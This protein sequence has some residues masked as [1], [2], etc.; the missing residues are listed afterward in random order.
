MASLNDIIKHLSDHYEF[1]DSD[2]IKAVVIDGKL[3]LTVSSK[4]LQELG[5]DQLV[6]N[7]EINDVQ[8]IKGPST[9]RVYQSIEQWAMLKTLQ[10]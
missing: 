2:D 3:R 8:T 10:Q 7:C 6:L 1:N 4:N 5:V 9:S